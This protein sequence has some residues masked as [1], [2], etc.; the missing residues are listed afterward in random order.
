MSK[1][2]K[3]DSLYAIPLDYLSSMSFSGYIPIDTE[4][5]EIRLVTIEQA[6]DVDL[7][8]KC[9]LSIAC[10]KETPDFK[11]L[12]YVWG[13]ASITRPIQLNGKT[14]HVTENLFRALLASRLQSE[15]CVYWIDAICINQQDTSEKNNQVL[16]M[17]E[18]YRACSLLVVWLGDESDDSDLACSLIVEWGEA[19]Q[20]FVDEHG[21]LPETA[22][23]FQRILNAVGPN[24]FDEASW[25]ALGKLFGR[26]WWWRI[27]VVQEF[28]KARVRV[29]RCGSVVF[30]SDAL[31]YAWGAW[32]DLKTCPAV[33]H[34]MAPEAAGMLLTY[35]SIRFQALLDIWNYDRPLPLLEFLGILYR[36]RFFKSTDPKDKLYGIIG[37]V[38]FVDYQI[39]PHYEW[40]RQQVYT[41]FFR[42]LLETTK[43]LQIMCL[44]GISSVEAGHTCTLPSWVPHLDCTM[45]A[46]GF[47]LPQ[48][49]NKAAGDSMAEAHISQNSL[50][51]FVEGLFH[52]S[53]LLVH[54]F[55]RP[56]YPDDLDERISFLSNAL[57]FNGNAGRVFKDFEVCL[58]LSRSFIKSRYPTGDTVLL[59]LFCLLTRKDPTKPSSVHLICGYCAMLVSFVSKPSD[60]SLEEGLFK[61]GVTEHPHQKL[62]HA[63]WG[64]REVPGFFLTEDLYLNPSIP[65][66]LDAASLS[67]KNSQCFFITQNQYIGIGPRAM[68]PDDKIFVPFGCDV[69]LVIRFTGKEYVVIG[70]C[71]IYGLM[72]GEIM[73]ELKRGNIDPQELEFI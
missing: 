61:S 11:A 17:G 18:I 38:S 72:K 60:V 28:A 33:L 25:N 8:I 27:W 20:K 41:G 6:E 67:W 7:P 4:K 10:L 9:T 53:V 23:E 58:K 36:T 73:E 57:S 13:D 69:P 50:S 56:S 66:F 43:K 3:T 45:S 46:V 16:L 31:L 15:D 71:W 49:G 62:D 2:D 48:G 24:V 32:D 39:Q 64:S 40:S 63:F 44:S 70:S 29:F 65:P 68:R 1:K 52:S 34:A 35:G 47:D 30:D 37:L 14:F 54:L 59:A 26:P 22:E 42:T 55:R 19:H 51:L 5:Q 21:R 12:S